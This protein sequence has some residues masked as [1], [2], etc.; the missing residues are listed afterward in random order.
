MSPANR[1][2]PVSLD[3]LSLTDSVEHAICSRTLLSDLDFLFAS[4]TPSNLT[5]PELSLRLSRAPTIG[6]SESQSD[7][8]LRDSSKC[9]R[10]LC[11]RFGG[12]S[13][14]RPPRTAE[15]VGGLWH[16]AYAILARP[17]GRNSLAIGRGTLLY[18]DNDRTFPET[19]P[20]RIRKPT[21]THRRP[22][23]GR[24]PPNALAPS[25]TACGDER[26]VRSGSRANDRECQSDVASTR[27][28]VL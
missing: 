28:R 22:N 2:R 6:Y 17:D 9:S 16:G 8:P 26:A 24:T 5:L 18:S 23:R 11:F 15:L 4:P 20:K 19:P 7:S 1:I 12:L 13:H 25:S 14:L 10:G 21:G 3:L 27:R